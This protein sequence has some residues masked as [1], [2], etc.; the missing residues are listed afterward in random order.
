MRSESSNKKVEINRHRAICVCTVLC[1]APLAA[2]AAGKTPAPDAQ[3][4]CSAT[5]QAAR[6]ACAFDGQ[7]DYF[8]TLGKCMNITDSDKRADCKER[9][10]ERRAN[11]KPAC[12]A[13]FQSRND[14]CDEVGQA[15]YD[16]EIDPA[17]F[18]DP[19][20]I[21][22]GVAP[23]NYYPLVRGSEWVYRGGGELN[24]VVVTGETRE[25]LG[26]TCAIIHDVVRSE[27][28]VTEDTQDF[29]AQDLAGNIW[30]FGEVSQELEDGFLESIEG[31][32]LAGRER[33]K[34]G[35]IFEAAPQVSDAYRQEFALGEAEDAARVLSTTASESVPA[36]SCDG[37][38]V[39]TE[40]FNL[41]EPD[42]LEHKYYAP[43]VGTILELDPEDGGRIELIS[44][45]IGPEAK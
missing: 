34:P 1:A 10:A 17:Q 12:N 3:G 33:A 27:G 9:A 35:I 28:E 14:F 25:I 44:Y 30:Y 18:V 20:D 15:P 23:N 42:S 45:H 7:D 21:G 16:P 8:L 19:A 22:H 26:V 4:A 11:I 31:S 38:C 6:V 41:L 2:L 39:L 5:A 36:V 29:L 32:W 37:T 43:G 40:D 13:R 24:T